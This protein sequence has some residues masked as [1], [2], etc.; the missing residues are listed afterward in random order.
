[1]SSVIVFSAAEQE[2]QELLGCCKSGLHSTPVQK[3]VCRL[4][5][6]CNS[7]LLVINDNHSLRPIRHMGKYYTQPVQAC[8]AHTS[9]Q[10]HHA[11]MSV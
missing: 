4:R 10:Q 5:A 1:M 7:D 3:S 8:H 9:D 11:R 2:F 6:I